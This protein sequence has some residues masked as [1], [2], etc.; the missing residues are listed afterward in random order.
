MRCY[1]LA[2]FSRNFITA[3]AGRRKKI[4]DRAQ[5]APSPNV[6][7][8]LSPQ[9]RNKPSLFGY[10]FLK[11]IRTCF[12]SNFSHRQLR[13]IW[14]MFWI[15]QCQRQSNLYLELCMA[16]FVVL[17][18]EGHHYGHRKMKRYFFRA[19]IYWIFFNAFNSLQTSLTIHE[20]TYVIIHDS[21]L[22]LLICII[23]K[24]NMYARQ[25]RAIL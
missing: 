14:I 11:F 23:L 15:K 10:V 4:P 9:A 25:F 13:Q 17:G 2:M 16:I 5:T 12:D 22:P 20:K 21:R 24:S 7:S 8:H 6:W 3:N 1:P 18:A 19:P